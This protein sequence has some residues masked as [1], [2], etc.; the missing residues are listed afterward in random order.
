[1]HGGLRKCGRK[2]EGEKKK[3][4]EAGGHHFRIILET[5]KNSTFRSSG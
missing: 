3:K 2:K 4:K 5:S 1:M